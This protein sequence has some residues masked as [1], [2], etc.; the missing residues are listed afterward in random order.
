VSVYPLSTQF[1]CSR[2]GIDAEN[3]RLMHA[4]ETVPVLGVEGLRPVSTRASI[5]DQQTNQPRVSAESNFRFRCYRTPDKVASS[6]ISPNLIR[7][8]SVALA[9]RW[10]GRRRKSLRISHVGLQRSPVSVSH[11]VG[12]PGHRPPTGT[13]NFRMLISRAGRR[14]SAR[15]SRYGV[16]TS[17]IHFMNARTRRDRLLRCATT[18]DTAS[19]RRRKSGMISTSAPL[20]KYRPI[21][22]SGA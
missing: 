9:R 14:C 22:K 2:R 3:H 16:S 6:R 10:G 12:P 1:G 7:N 18:R 8:G 15:Y 4:G 17:S 20:S 11:S 13:H 19:A 21:P 5:N